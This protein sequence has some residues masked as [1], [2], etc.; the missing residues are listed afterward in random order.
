MIART[1]DG[2]AL[3]QFARDLVGAIARPHVGLTPVRAHI[4]CP[5]SRLKLRAAVAAV[6]PLSLASQS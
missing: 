5:L 4:H 3:R 6:Q 2:L 1:H